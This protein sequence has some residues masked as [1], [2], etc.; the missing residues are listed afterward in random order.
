LNTAARLFKNTAALSLAEIFSKLVNFVFVAVLA[1]LL[2]PAEFG[3][4]TLLVTLTWVLTALADLGISQ[5]MVREIAVQR[6]ASGRLLSSALMIS[7]GVA[8]VAWAGLVAWGWFG[9]Y[10]ESLR[11][12]IFLAGGI[13]FGNVLAQTASA[14]LRAFERME[15]QALLNSGLLLVISL[16]GVAL[17]LAG[18][19]LHA[20][21][22]SNL[23]FAA[24]ATALTLVIVHRWFTPLQWRVDLGAVWA[25][26]RQ[27]LP[28]TFLFLCSAILRWSDVLILGQVR[29]L[30]DVALYGS[31]VRVVELAFVL[32]N[33][34]AAALLP[35]LSVQ[36][37]RDHAAAK[38]L[39]A[40]A[41]RFFGTLGLAVA[42]GLTILAESVI[43]FVFGPEYRSAALPLR[44][45]G[46][47]YFFQVSNAPM[48]LLLIAAQ[49][50]VRRFIP[51]IGLVTLGN[52][53]LNLLLAPHFGPPGSACAFL[54]TAF[55]TVFIR[56]RVA[57]AYF[58]APPRLRS[59][60]LRPLLAGLGMAAALF[61]LRDLPAPAT[62]PTGAAIFG[63]LLLLLGEFKQEPYRS[64]WQNLRLRHS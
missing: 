36:W 33:S 29:S 9:P 51:A 15:I 50:G 10:A 52:L 3:G 53:L 27:A 38:A 49:E 39:Y 43:D 19:G 11:A 13:V 37:Q 26:A 40:H 34:A 31:A 25:L 41:L 7:A 4:Y 64:L 57:T 21:I 17:A 48:W 23:I 14:A 2:T 16:A 63:A 24:S 12:L 1:R 28:I 30:E 56:H 58:P 54:L 44:I 35:V 55:A 59:L 46:W 42:F 8:L 5:V 6:Q 62:V 60:L 47:T 18:F 20:Q 22:W 45:L 32:S 61:L